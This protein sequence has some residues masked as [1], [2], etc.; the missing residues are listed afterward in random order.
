VK[1]LKDVLFNFVEEALPELEA[2]EQVALPM[3]KAKSAFHNVVEA[4]KDLQNLI[5]V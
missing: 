5:P 1:S 3:E 4:K 2:F